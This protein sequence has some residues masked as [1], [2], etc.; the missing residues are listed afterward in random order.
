MKTK[1]FI[2][3]F[4]ALATSAL[5]A[6]SYSDYV[7]GLS[8]TTY[9]RLDQAV[10][11]TGQVVPNLGTLVAG[12]GTYHTYGGGV[13]VTTGASGGAIAGNAGITTTGYAVDIMPGGPAGPHPDRYAPGNTAFSVS[14][15]VK[16]TSFGVGDYDPAFSYGYSSP[17]GQCIL[18]SENGDAGA[19]DGGIIVGRYFDNILFSTGK[20]TAGAWNSIGLT[21]DGGTMRLYLNGNADNTWTGTLN[22]FTTFGLLGGLFT[23]EAAYN[24]GLDEYAYWNGTALNATQMGGLA[25]PEPSTWALLAIGLTVVVTLRRRNCLAS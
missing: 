13:T 6:D 17:I 11:T 10:T 1:V 16:P 5:Y 25:V 15:W 19:G 22:S 23:G 12:N 24:G 3:A 7:L 9:F 21:W 8:P 2:A 20:L 4:V 18:I 14:L